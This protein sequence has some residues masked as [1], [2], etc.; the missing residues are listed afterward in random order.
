MEFR[1]IKLIIAFVS[2]ALL[3]L[4]AVQL[5]WAY[6]SY[7]M[8]EKTFHSKANAAMRKAVETAND[9][10]GCVELFSKVRI[11]PK[12]GFYIIRQKFDAK[13]EFIRDSMAIDTIP[14]YFANANDRMPF[15]FSDV[16]FRS[17]LNLEMVA[18]LEYFFDD[19]ASVPF[20]SNVVDDV[21]IKNFREKFASNEPIAVRYTTLVFD[22]ILRDELHS[23]SIYD[24][25]HFGYIR[26]DNNQLHFRTEGAHDKTLM[27]SP[28]RVRLTKDKYFSQPYDL[29]MYFNDYQAVLFAGIRTQLIISFLVI[30]ILLIGFY[31]FIRIIYR[32][33]KLSELK[34]DFI[35]NMTHEFKTPLANIS[36]ALENLAEKS[37]GEKEPNAKL[38]R[39][40]GQETERLRE[41][42]EKI[43]QV[44]RLEKE[45]IHLSFEKLDVHSVIQKAVSPFEPVLETRKASV[46]FVFNAAQPVIEADETHLINIICNLIDNSIKYSSN[47]LRLQFRTENTHHGIIFSVIDNGEGI[48]KEAQKRIFEKFY[49]ANNTDTHTVKG[50]GLGLVYVKTI[51]DSHKG[52]I[53]VKSQENSGSEFQIYLPFNQ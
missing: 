53:V 48:S 15:R 29:V 30:L 14:L 8:S 41:N 38:Y 51:V 46:E 49:R 3:S 13:G 4:I 16:S 40:L 45:K 10:I 27:K 12:E 36:I 31:L 11:N 22:S 44:A 7:R 21:N 33:R 1:R 35:N 42:I 37:L 26:S 6:S 24:E 17:A 20:M 34:N 18:K 5:F 23:F 9:H 39:I 19:T 52:K 2:F 50:F 32:Q 28:L 43:L 25:F 47:G